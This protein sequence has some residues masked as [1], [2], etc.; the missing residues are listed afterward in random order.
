LTAANTPVRARCPAG[1]RVRAAKGNLFMLRVLLSSVVMVLFLSAGFVRADDKDTKDAKHPKQK[2]TITKVDKNKGT[3]TVKMK[4]KEGKEVE[5]TFKLTEDIRYLDSTGKVAAIDIFR[6]GDE[7]LVVEEEG[8]LK[9]LH[10]HKGKESEDTEK[11]EKSKVDKSP[12]K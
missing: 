12:R 5:K 10:Q 7:V 6:S 11:N 4:H 9:E 8:Q 3:I 2:A 1:G